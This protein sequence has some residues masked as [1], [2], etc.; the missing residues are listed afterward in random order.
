MTERLK[1]GELAARAGVQKSTVQHY[2][3]EGLLPGP[4][5]KPHRNVAYY[6][7]D[8]VPRIQ[9]IKQLQAEKHL[10]LSK[11]KTLMKGNPAV[12]GLREHLRAG[13]ER[14]SDRSVTRSELLEQA[15]L[16]AKELD[17]FEK[18][19]LVR[20]E[21][22]DGEQTYSGSDA[23]IVRGAMA[24]RRAGFEKAGFRVDDLVFYMDAMRALVYQEVAMFTRVMGKDQGRDELLQMARAGMDGTNELLIALRRKLYL[25]LLQGSDPKPE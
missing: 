14:P 21:L 20:H 1:I 6:S 17:R 9:L 22:R 13:L 3:R 12:D 24:M 5:D 8:L 10:P 19:G 18:L 7:A 15:H 25:E 23:A 16:T 11:I 4:V 2:L